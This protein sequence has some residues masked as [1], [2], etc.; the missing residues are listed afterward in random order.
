[1]KIVWSRRAAA[2]LVAIRE[3]VEQD[4]PEAAGRLARR[5]REAVE[6]LARHP[7]MGRPGRVQG[8]RELVLRAR[9]M[10]FLTG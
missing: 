9:H 5:I 8:T 6:Q 1:M 10:S 3:Y 7:L 2:H 4:N